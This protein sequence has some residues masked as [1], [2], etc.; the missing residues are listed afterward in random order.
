M[1]VDLEADNGKYVCRSSKSFV[2]IPKQNSFIIIVNTSYEQLQAKELLL[3][4]IGKKGAPNGTIQIPIASITSLIL[5][6]AHDMS[7][8]III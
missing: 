2:S 4:H 5:Y 1:Y 7:P 6:V 8:D 3:H